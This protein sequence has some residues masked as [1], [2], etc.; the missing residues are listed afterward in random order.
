MN[1]KV[2]VLSDDTTGA[3]VNVSLNNPTYGYIRVSQVRTM[4]DDNG[5]L[6]RKPVSALIAGT[7][8]ELTEANFFAGQ[9][10]DG[11]IVVEEALSPFNEKTPERDLKIA[12]ETGVVCTVGGLPIYRRTKF[13]FASNSEDLLIKHDNVEQLKAAYSTQKANTSVLQ[14]ARPTEDFNIGG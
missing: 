9:Q 11:K 4:I 14:N 3:V 5:F 8:T 10:L 13:S 1:S 6:R 2:T 7:V 12:G